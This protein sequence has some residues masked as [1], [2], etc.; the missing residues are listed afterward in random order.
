MRAFAGASSDEYKKSPSTRFSDF[1]VG[2]L[3][4]RGLQTYDFKSKR[5]RDVDRTYTVSKAMVRLASSSL[6]CCACDRYSN[7]EKLWLYIR[8]N[9][10]HAGVQYTDRV[11][12]I[13]TGETRARKQGVL[14]FEWSDLRIGRPFPQSIIP[15]DRTSSALVPCTMS[16][17]ANAFIAFLKCEARNHEDR[18]RNLRATAA[19]IEANA[20]GKSSA[21]LGHPMQQ[22]VLNVYA[23]MV[24]PIHTDTRMLG[25]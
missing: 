10:F 14:V 24:G 6:S 3:A 21:V 4:S 18:A 20:A 25:F 7:L 9:I 19:A 11:S 2:L 8:Y 13:R 16:G 12:S 5:S 17:A 1:G 23:S 15:G 22:L